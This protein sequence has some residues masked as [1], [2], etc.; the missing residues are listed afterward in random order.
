[1]RAKTIVP[2]EGPSISPG[3][4]PQGNPPFPHSGSDAYARGKTQ[5]WYS[6]V[7][8]GKDAVSDISPFKLSAAN[9]S[10]PPPQSHDGGGRSGFQGQG[11]RLPVSP[12]RFSF[13]FKTTFKDM[14]KTWIQFSQEELNEVSLTLHGHKT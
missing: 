10:P 5:Q 13:S 11:S 12:S 9:V 8:G 7:P 3:M 14:H 4:G 2:P 1:M 6:H